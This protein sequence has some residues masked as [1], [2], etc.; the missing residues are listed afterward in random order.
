MSTVP[1][2]WFMSTMQGAPRLSGTAGDM[3]GLLDAC[4]INGFNVTA[5]NSLAVLGGIASLYYSGGGHGYVLHQVI[6]V[7]G[8]T[9]EA[10][11]GEWRVTEVD[12]NYVRFAAPG[13][14]DGTASGTIGVR[15]APLGWDKVFSGT[16]KAVYRSTD[17]AGTRLY[18]RVD[19]TAAQ[20]TYARGY[21]EMTDVDTGTG[22]FPTAAQSS[23]G[24]TWPK[25]NQAST[26]AR[27]WLVIGDTRIVYAFV[28]WSSNYSDN[29]DGN[30]FGDIQSFKDA[31]TY[32]SIIF[33]T[34]SQTPVFPGQYFS[35]LNKTD[36]KYISRAL[37]QTGAAILVASVGSGVTTF[38]GLTAATYP[39]PADNGLH[40]HE[41]VLILDGTSATSPVRGQYPGLLQCVQNIPLSHADIVQI[42]GDYVILVAAAYSAIQGRCAFYLTR[43]WR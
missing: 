42:G 4:L 8:A 17:V 22:L 10:L 6:A 27:N 25:S 1:V 13:E 19:D 37:S 18:L 14:P 15:A 32:S 16:N 3:I 28:A 30:V 24:V 43:P 20:Y 36:G 38:L 9:P 34:N 33:G 21:E 41:P 5:P 7:S 39:A 26:S 2:K 23:W 31:D 40:L 12:A 35:Q 11:N 29:Y